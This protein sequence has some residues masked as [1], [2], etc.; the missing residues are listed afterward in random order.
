MKQSR[1]VWSKGLRVVE[2]SEINE[3][4]SYIFFYTA[5]SYET[6]TAHSLFQKRDING[7][8]ERVEELQK[9]IIQERIS[10]LFLKSRQGPYFSGSFFLVLFP[11]F[12]P[13]AAA[14]SSKDVRRIG[15]V[16]PFCRKNCYVAYRFFSGQCLFTFYAPTGLFWPSLLQNPQARTT[17]KLIWSTAEYKINANKKTGF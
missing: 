7:L 1:T 5:S 11:L 12:F 8:F 10:Y 17:G 2:Q 15:A 4:S 9:C 6:K 13:A 14:R 16:L 3:K